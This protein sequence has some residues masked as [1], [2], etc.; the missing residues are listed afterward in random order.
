MCGAER[1]N[2]PDLTLSPSSPLVSIRYNPKDVHLLL[3]GCYNGQVAIWDTR[4]GS[5]PIETS[6]VEQ[7]HRDP[8]YAA[9]YLA[10]KTGQCPAEQQRVVR[11][12][13]VCWCVCVFCF[14]FVIVLIVKC[15]TPWAHTHAHAH[16]RAR[17]LLWTRRH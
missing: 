8:V 14:C 16:T 9:E 10:S 6:P 3:G 2:V 17:T 7:S 4:K 1:P 5:R 12:R 11:L 13:C 15:W